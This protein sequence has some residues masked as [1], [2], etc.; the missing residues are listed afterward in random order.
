MLR[1][2]KYLRVLLLRKRKTVMMTGRSA[3]PP[4]RAL[5]IN[6]KIKRPNKLTEIKKSLFCRSLRTSGEAGGGR[7]EN[8]A[9]GVKKI[10]L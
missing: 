2:E 7:R 3:P 8:V 9:W 4:T 1:S 5:A 6:P 10:V